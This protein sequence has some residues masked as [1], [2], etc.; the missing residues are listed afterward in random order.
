MTSATITMAPS[1]LF[2][3]T[4]PGLTAVPPDAKYGTSIQVST[5]QADQIAS[6]CLIAPSAVTHSFN[7]NPRYVPLDFQETGGGVLTI[8]LPSSQA[9]APPGY[10]ML[11]LVNGAGV[12]SIGEFIRLKKKYRPPY[13]PKK[14]Y[15][16]NWVRTNM[17]P[18][19]RAGVDQ[20]TS[21]RSVVES[22]SHSP[23]PLTT[24][25]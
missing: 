1:Y 25:S 19:P 14:Q 16:A 8:D 20:I 23:S 9:L 11:F 6:A 2:K 4:R 3:G 21:S 18:S 13:S 22:T 7:Q 5:D 15:S 12:P 24:A 10:Y 17:S